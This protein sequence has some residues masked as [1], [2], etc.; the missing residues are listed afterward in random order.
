[1]VFPYGKGPA[2]LLASAKQGP[3]GHDR[4][5]IGENASDLRHPARFA[6]ERNSEGDAKNAPFGQRDRDVSTRKPVCDG[7]FR[8]NL[9]DGIG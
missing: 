7:M 1:M 9:F 2:G 8:A 5:V 6:A 4:T 3:L